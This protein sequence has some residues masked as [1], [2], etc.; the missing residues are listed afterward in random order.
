MT[1]KFRN[2][3][4]PDL[5]IELDGRTKNEVLRRLFKMCRSSVSKWEEVK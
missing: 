1:I 5:T 3:A 4:N 2:K